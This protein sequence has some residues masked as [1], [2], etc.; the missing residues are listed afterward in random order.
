MSRCWALGGSPG[1]P[2][3]LLTPERGSQ[4]RAPPPALWLRA[5]V[6][7]SHVSPFQLS[8]PGHHVT[9]PFCTQEKRC[10][11]SGS[12]GSTEQWGPRPSGHRGQAWGRML[13]KPP[14]AALMHPSPRQMPGQHCQCGMGAGAKFPH[15]LFHPQGSPRA[16]WPRYKPCRH[17]VLCDCTPVSMRHEQD[18]KAIAF[19]A[20]HAFACKLLAE[21]L[22]PTKE[23][24]QV[25]AG[26]VVKPLPRWAALALEHRAAAGCWHRQCQP[27][28]TSGQ[29]CASNTSPWR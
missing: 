17:T 26:R 20:S 22:S 24:A 29:S 5:A 19:F 8:L 10:Q 23:E 9:Q 27:V 3:T 2:H 21:G 16:P 7:A 4:H 15:C 13:R 18:N 28:A 25:L 11:P 6:S 14:W 1:G 12:Q